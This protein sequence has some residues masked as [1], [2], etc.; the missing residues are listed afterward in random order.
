[1]NRG[2]GLNVLLYGE[3]TFHQVHGGAATSHDGY[4]GASL[5]EFTEVTGE[6]Y[7]WPS[8]PFLADLGERYGRMQA[9]GR[10]IEADERIAESGSAPPPCV[11][12]LGMHRSGTSLLTG[13]LEAAGL[14][15]GKVNHAAPF[16]RKGNKENEPIRGFHDELLAKNGA[17]WD[18]PPKGQVR[19]DRPDEER[20]RSL[21]EAH[22]RSARPW[23]FKDPRPNP[24]QT[25]GF[26][27][28]AG[29]LKR[30]PA[31]VATL[32]LTRL[33]SERLQRGNSN[34][35]RGGDSPRA[36]VKV[37]YQ[38]L[39]SKRCHQVNRNLAFHGYKPP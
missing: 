8:F 22:L 32:D 5:T 13:S 21:I 18:R 3:S 30:R 9:V 37:T 27:G 17:S 4:F 12:V 26:A 16:N 28:P 33:S 15:L 6:G 19:W 23:G 31:G 20:A 24:V 39:A 10:F 34:L 2:R 1:M 25:I 36:N 14:H 11:I 7:E 35:I 29:K 38:L